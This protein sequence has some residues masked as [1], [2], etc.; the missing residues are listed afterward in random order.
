MFLLFTKK[1]YVWFNKKRRIEE[2]KK[3]RGVE[4]NPKWRVYKY[5]RIVATRYQSQNWRF[6]SNEKN[7]YILLQ[8]FVSIKI[9][10]SRMSAYSLLL[11]L[12]IVAVIIQ[13]AVSYPQYYGGYGL[14]G[15]EFNGGTRS[16]KFKSNHG[17]WQQLLLIFTLF[18]SVARFHRSSSLWTLVILPL[19]MVC[20]YAVI[21]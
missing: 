15:P 18:F 11:C 1:K 16:S 2:V 7:I 8:N 9:Y 6:S 10:S 13:V 21:L 20:K 5:T 12:L 14:S 4:T 17:E 19:T 3:S